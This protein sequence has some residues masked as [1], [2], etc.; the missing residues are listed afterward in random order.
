[1]N[2]QA[3]RDAKLLRVVDISGF[4][5]SLRIT[6]NILNQP[7]KSQSAD[8]FYSFDDRFCFFNDGVHGVLFVV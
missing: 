7:K 2:R 1:V 4:S 5:L 8:L 3:I 6:G